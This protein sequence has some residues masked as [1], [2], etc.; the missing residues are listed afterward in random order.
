MKFIAQRSADET[1]SIAREGNCLGTALSRESAMVL[2]LA[3]LRDYDSLDIVEPNCIIDCSGR[4]AK[5]SLDTLMGKPKI[6]IG[7][8][9]YT[10]KVEGN[11]TESIYSN[12]SPNIWRGH[13]KC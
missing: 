6:N 2:L 1:W 3:E 5:A 7:A 8:L 9:D 10:I 11:L 13:P 12:G 4:L